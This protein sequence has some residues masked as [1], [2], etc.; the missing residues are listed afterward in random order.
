M[1]MTPEQKSAIR[2]A[3]LQTRK[4]ESR[5][6]TL[7]GIEIELRQQS[8]DKILGNMGQKEVPLLEQ[9]IRSFIDHA[10]YPDT[11]E[12]IFTHH[13]IEAIKLWPFSKEW[14]SVQKAINELSGMLETDVDAAEKDITEN[15]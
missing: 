1:S 13:D 6:I 2:G 7:N 11:D 10:Y 3:L 12:R 8:L 9:T 5:R 4:I 14:L 15:P